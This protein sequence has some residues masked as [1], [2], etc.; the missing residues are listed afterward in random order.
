MGNLILSSYFFA[1]HALKQ[2]KSCLDVAK[3]A[4]QRERQRA[5]PAVPDFNS[6]L[7]VSTDSS[8]R[9]TT[10]SEWV[11][12]P[13]STWPPSS[14]TSLLRSWS[15]PVTPPVT[16]RRPESSPDIFSLPSVTTRS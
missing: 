7:V 14:S 1:L 6:P 12:V 15:W 4:K 8:A 2:P 5:D 16:T 11:P 3:E 9:E 13:P 10:P